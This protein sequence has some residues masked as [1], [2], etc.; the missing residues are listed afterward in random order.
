[1]KT[2]HVNEQQNQEETKMETIKTSL[3]VDC[4][5]DGF[6][7]IVRNKDGSLE[8]IDSEDDFDEA[9]EIEELMIGN[10]VFTT[11]R[12]RQ[13]CAEFH[14]EINFDKEFETDT[15]GVYA[16]YQDR[17]GFDYADWAKN[18]IY[19]DLEEELKARGYKL[20]PD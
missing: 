5:N 1:M 14:P 4:L 2:K 11:Y 3:F 10:P 13:Y 16:R 7:R 17:F 20:L 15:P 12:L 18:E 9:T 6:Y 19:N 8:L